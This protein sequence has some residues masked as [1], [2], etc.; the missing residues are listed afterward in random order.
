VT[1]DIFLLATGMF[2]LYHMFRVTATWKI[3]TGIF[4]S[5]LVFVIARVLQLQGILWIYENLSPVLLIAMI[6]IFQPEIRKI[7]ERVASMR[8][9]Q[10][11]GEVNKECHLLSDAMFTLAQK[12]HG[13]LVVVTGKEL[14][15]AW[16]SKGIAIDARLSFPILVSIFDPSSPGHDGAVII[17]NGRLS[18]FGVHLPLSKH[19]SLADNYGTRHH[20]AMG[21]SKVSDALIIAVSEERG[22]VSAFQYGSHR[23]IHNAAELTTLLV[24]HIEK[25]A[26]FDL[27][28]LNIKK[29]KNSILE[30]AICVILAFLFR[31]SVILT[32]TG[33]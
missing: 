1:L 19:G 7:F 6:I 18:T 21:L 5:A 14:L 16:I 15:Q 27:P 9:R 12:R 22:T 11:V 3:L 29:R 10:R 31:S 28:G 30:L 26:S 8:P 33:N 4:F 25:N 13:A 23:L 2:L 17:E 32:S 24:G 20:A